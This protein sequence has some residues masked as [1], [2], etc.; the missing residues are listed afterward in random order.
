[1]LAE[2]DA[3]KCVRRSTAGES[4]RERV[5][6]RDWYSRGLGPTTVQSIHFFPVTDDRYVAERA[7]ERA[8]LDACPF[9]PEGGCGVTGHGSHP[10]VSPAG[11]RVARFWCALAGESISLLPSFLASRLSGTLDEIESAVATVESAESHA[12]AAE[13]LRPADAERAV[14]SISAARWVRRRVRPIRVALLALVTLVPE[15]ERCAPTVIAFRARLGVA[16]V[17]LALREIARSHLGSLSPP[18]GLCARGGR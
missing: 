12:A 4:A 18:L 3:E 16:R 6:P 8:V 1:M 17:L 11:V 13:T 2:R 5:S 10:R 7:W 9:H 15:L 14:T